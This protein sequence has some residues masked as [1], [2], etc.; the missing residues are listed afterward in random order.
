MVI[1]RP[2]S[3]AHTIKGKKHNKIILNMENNSLNLYKISFAEDFFNSLISGILD[4]ISPSCKIKDFTILLP[5]KNAC[6]E[7]ENRFENYPEKPR[8]YSISN[9]N[10]YLLNIKI[11]QNYASRFSLLKRINKILSSFISDDLN[12]TLELSDYLFKLL[13]IIESYNISFKEIIPILT[14]END[15]YK[16]KIS[17]ILV[18]FFEEWEEEKTLTPAGYNNLLIKNL[19]KEKLIIAGINSTLPSILELYQ[20]NIN[21]KDSYII[22]SGIDDYLTMDNWQNI[23]SNNAQTVNAQICKYL[24]IDPSKIV[25]WSKD[26]KKSSE[27]VSLALRSAHQCDNWHELNNLATDNIE[28]YLASDQYDEAKIIVNLLQNYITENSKVLIVTP[29]ENLT[30]NLKLNLE[31]ANIDFNIIRDFPLKSSLLGRW[32]DLTLNY[33]TNRQ[34][35][36]NLI[37]LLKHPFSFATEDEL[38]KLEEIIR[39]SNIKD[40]FSLSM[41]DYPFL[42]KLRIHLNNFLAITNFSTF[43]NF[44]EQHLLFAQN[45]SKSE[46]WETQEAL[47]LKEYFTQITSEYEYFQ[48]IN[49]KEYISLYSFFMASAFYR[50]EITHPKNITLVKPI[51]ARLFKSDI[52]I[53]AGLNKDI[54]PN[55]VENDLVIKNLG[56]NISD[57]Y[58]SENAHDFQ[59]FLNSE[60]II[61]TSSE[62]IAGSNISPSPWLQRIL[63]LA[64]MITKKNKI[65]ENSFFFSQSINFAIPPI[66][67]RPQKLSVTQFEKLIFNPYHIYIDAILNLKKYPKILKEVSSLDFGNFIHKAIEIKF[68]HPEYNFA[69]AGQ[70]ALN[71]LNLDQPQIKILWWPRFL[72]ITNWYE[73]NFKNNDYTYL[74]VKGH[75]NI[76]SNF[77]ITAKADYLE[78]KQHQVDIFDFKTG[79]IPTIKSINDGKS[80]QLLL[81]GIIAENSGF[82]GQNKKNKYQVESLKY[83]QLTGGEEV[84]KIL[85]V[86][87]SQE[88]FNKTYSYVNEIINAYKNPDMPY[89]Y[90]KKK[91]LSY[92]HYAHLARDF[93]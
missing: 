13:N 84:A 33:L 36:I 49:I 77:I 32:L 8:I 47:K 70:K 64:K 37:T 83:I 21:K 25:S 87:F 53:L 67:S 10:D 14:Q 85:S 44:L 80:L 76:S 54:W 5:T 55:K 35:I 50:P 60:K 1:F 71:L 48:A 29:D 17:K 45:I 92:C 20:R 43:N 63:T 3:V 51:D 28:H 22:L 61:L 78:I 56:I 73:N 79:I 69:E 72:R 88:L 89:Y 26:E 12:L 57:K 90:T 24:D 52:I 31:F 41:L 9:L 65:E 16:Q 68:F 2:E 39:N 19:N 38:I 40:I 82:H 59:N 27:F 46:L 86:K 75:L 11:T 4:K 34:S 18:K 7:L 93:N 23:S 81:E 15:L 91:L 66:E 30:I 58:I 6:I 42:E 62:K 74:E